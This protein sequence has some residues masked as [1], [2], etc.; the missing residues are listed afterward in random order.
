MPCE[1]VQVDGQSWD[2]RIAAFWA[3]ADDGHAEATLATMKRPVDERPAT[4]PDALYEWASVHDFLGREAEAV[5]LYLAALEAGLGGDRE[6]RAVIQLAS[7]LR[8]VGEPEAAVDL[9]RCR[10]QDGVTG[11][12]E[13]AFLALALYDAGQPRAALRTALRAL[14]PTLPLYGGAVSSYAD[15][16]T[17]SNGDG[18]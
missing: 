14:A 18:R 1:D 11:S 8:N 10:P 5:P 6:P 15:E 7:S 2:E 3:S 17:Y 13:Q 16:L 9:L 4:D 12:A